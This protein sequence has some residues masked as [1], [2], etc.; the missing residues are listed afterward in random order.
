MT[1]T[2]KNNSPTDNAENL[3]PRLIL[4]M[5]ADVDPDELGEDRFIGHH[6]LD[7]ALAQLQVYIDTVYREAWTD[8][9]HKGWNTYNEA[10]YNP[11]KD[12]PNE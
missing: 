8:G 3:T 1:T 10:P 2:P 11:N 6:S 5:Y 12:T 9:Y 7:K 4:Q